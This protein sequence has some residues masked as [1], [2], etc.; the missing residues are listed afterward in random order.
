M[1]RPFIAAAGSLGTPRLAPARPP[2]RTGFSAEIVLFEANEPPRTVWTASDEMVF[3]LGDADGSSVLAGT[4]PKGRLY[5]VSSDTWALERTF[6]EKQVTIVA[7]DA[8]ATNGASAFY[9]LRPG[10]RSG[11]FQ[12]RIVLGF[13]DHRACLAAA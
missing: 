3:A 8:V 4:G 1:T 12:R 2:S 7:G 6:D 10:D 5:R 11:D 13:V 9:R